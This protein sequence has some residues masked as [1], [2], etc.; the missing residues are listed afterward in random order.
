M[1][2]TASEKG[3][4]R[5]A[6]CR[7]ERTG[8]WEPFRALVRAELEAGQA[9]EAARS[10]ELA[11]E[12]RNQYGRDRFCC[13]GLITEG[14]YWAI[15]AELGVTGN[16]R[17]EHLERAGYILVGTGWTP[18]GDVDA[19]TRALVANDGAAPF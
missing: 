16:L 17:K 12:R 7:A 4:R 2:F 3:R 10:R 18:Y 14:E 1:P 15:H 9:E 19:L 11:I 5:R 13:R 8:D 6:K